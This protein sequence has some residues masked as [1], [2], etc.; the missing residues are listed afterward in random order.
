MLQRV[1]CASS[2]R[3]L[4]AAC[5][6][7]Q[8]P[9]STH[10]RRWRSGRLGRYHCLQRSGALASSIAQPIPAGILASARKKTVSPRGRGF[11][12]KSNA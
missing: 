2:R 5:I 3:T 9:L 8:F 7:G 1:G 12:E 6:A 4:V 11:E 10:C